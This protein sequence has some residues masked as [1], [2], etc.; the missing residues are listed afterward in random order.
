M[1]FFRL[2]LVVGFGVLVGALG[3]GC[4]DNPEKEIYPPAQVPIRSSVDWG[5]PDLDVRAAV[6]DLEDRMMNRGPV[7]FR[8]EVKSTDPFPAKLRGTLRFEYRNVLHLEG[9]GTLKDA[10]FVPALQSNDERMEGGTRTKGFDVETPV[11]LRRS[12][13]VGF[14]R[15]GIL[16]NVVRVGNGLPPDH[17]DGGVDTWV[18]LENLRAEAPP[19]PD[20]PATRK[21]LF[22]LS[23]QGQRAGSG[24]LEVAIATGWPIRRTQTV[25]FAAGQME[26]E[27]TY[28]VF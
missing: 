27:E 14:I 11:E 22:D 26:V 4:A 5:A 21:I 1:S 23:V 6:V 10:P 8:W 9:E 12:I 24:T 7:G 17:A 19:L 16:H 28:Q 20:G 15:M 18:T 3:I 25:N 13:V 2:M